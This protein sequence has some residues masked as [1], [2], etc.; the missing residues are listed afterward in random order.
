ME[1]GDD[2]E[3][4]VE[5]EDTEEML[6]TYAAKIRKIYENVDE[7][8]MVTTLV[9]NYLDIEKTFILDLLVIPQAWIFPSP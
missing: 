9:K 1:L 5:D 8:Q 3:E 2:I 6:L 4:P 7:D